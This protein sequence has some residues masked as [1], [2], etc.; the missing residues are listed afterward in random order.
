MSHQLGSRYIMLETANGN[1]NPEQNLPSP[2]SEGLVVSSV[3]MT[4]QQAFP[5]WSKE[6][7]SYSRLCKWD[8]QER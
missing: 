5:C 8:R 4:T 6:L 3:R 7:K 2:A 1:I